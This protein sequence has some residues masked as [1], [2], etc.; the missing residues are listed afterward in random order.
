VE[1]VDRLLD[2]GEKGVELLARHMLRS[3]YAVSKK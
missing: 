2:E 1:L 3:R